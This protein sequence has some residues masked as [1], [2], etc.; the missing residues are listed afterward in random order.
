[1]VK[2]TLRCAI[3]LAG[4]DP[5]G[6]WSVHAQ[7][8]SPDVAGGIKKRLPA[9]FRLAAA[10][11]YGPAVE[12]I[13]D[14]Y[15]FEHTST[16]PTDASQY[17][18]MLITG[19]DEGAYDQHVPYVPL[20]EAYIAR[21]VHLTR[22]IGISYG[23]Q[24]IA[25]GLNPAGGNVVRNPNGWE[26]AAVEATLTE[27]GRSLLRT[28]KTGY[29]IHNHH[30]DAVLKAPPGTTQVSSSE[31]T[32]VQSFISDRVFTN[33]GHMEYS[34]GIMN[35]Y[36]L[37]DSMNGLYSIPSFLQFLNTRTF[38]PCSNRLNFLPDAIWLVGKMVGW[39]LDDGKCPSDAEMDAGK[40]ENAGFAR[41]VKRRLEKELVEIEYEKVV[42]TYGGPDRVRRYKEALNRYIETGKFEKEKWIMESPTSRGM[43]GKE[44]LIRVA[45]F[46]P[47]NQETDWPPKFQVYSPDIAGGICKR[48][49]ALLRY[50]AALYFPTTRFLF[51]EYAFEDVANYPDANTVDLVILTGADD[52]AYD[53]HVPYIPEVERYVAENV[54]KTR[55][56]GISFGHQIIA[57][58]LN[59]GGGNVVKN[60]KGW[61]NSAVESIL[62]D[63]GRRTLKTEK[64]SYFIHNHHGDAVLS[65]PPGTVVVSTSSS[66][67]PVQSFISDRVF[68]NEGHLEYSAGIMENFG[69]WDTLSGAYTIEKYKEFLA[70]RT[71]LLCDNRLKFL[72]DAVWLAGKIVGWISND[73]VV[74]SDAEMAERK[75]I[76]QESAKLVLHTL[77]E[78]LLVNEYGTQV[79]KYGGMERVKA[80]KRAWETYLAGGGFDVD[81][82]SSAPSLKK[83][84]PKN[85][86]VAIMLPTDLYDWPVE[87]QVFSPDIAGGIRKRLPALLRLAAARY[88]PSTTFTFT[89][90]IFEK[91]DTW[92]KDASE[93]D[94]FLVTGAKEGAY[95]QH[96][97][98][99]PI[100][101]K[102]IGDNV[103]KSRFIGIS[104]GHQ[105]IAWGLNPGGRE[106][107]D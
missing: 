21:N 35:F 25:W 14:E 6:S 100:L 20:I 19:A 17:D 90:M 84:E 31:S 92:P 69:L 7:A 53:H 101:E 98:Y 2:R 45:M 32:P 11:Y 36:G 85:V 62:T 77:E 4:P 79:K 89:E 61:E 99:V 13:F 60:P 70:Q 8:F 102:Y 3:F 47:G 42:A 106:E 44:K 48:L 43:S 104:Y 46:I 12:F 75:E 55:F 56:L 91:T 5:D 33:E 22:F 54:N 96:V 41:T 16:W 1:M 29:Y 27:E 15:I 63:E 71:H 37:W 66:A 26:N 103:H 49:A 95:D 72:P 107:R 80:L 40:T 67:T 30:G 50:A 93:Y 86:K 88:Y 65:A 57:W 64:K 94:L 10:T 52:G 83:D 38:L 39:L 59:P 97:P 82:W 34:S 105:I 18:F 23:H 24:V 68:T 9:I 51:S 73:G 81:L 28:Q 76:N 87:M 78:E 58:G 74:P